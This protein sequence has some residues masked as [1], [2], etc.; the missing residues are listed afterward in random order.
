[1]ELH[2]RIALVS[3]VDGSPSH[4]ILCQVSIIPRPSRDD[5]VGAEGSRQLNQ[6]CARLFQLFAACGHQKLLWTAKHSAFQPTS[7]KFVWVKKIQN[8]YKHII[9]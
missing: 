6:Q 9:G 4:L 5:L 3:G 2:T 1:M 7:I 8:Q